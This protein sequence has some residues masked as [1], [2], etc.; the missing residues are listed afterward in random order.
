MRTRVV[1]DRSNEMDG[2][3][4]ISKSIRAVVVSREGNLTS[5]AAH[6]INS[7]SPLQSASPSIPSITETAAAT[8]QVEDCLSGHG[9]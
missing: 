6:P 4:N 5:S 8:D 3:R 7:D 2:Y 9:G 1:L